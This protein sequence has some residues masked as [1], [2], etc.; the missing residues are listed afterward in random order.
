MSRM[1]ACLQNV[2]NIQSPGPVENLRGLLD[3]SKYMNFE[4]STM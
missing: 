3:I 4:L 1:H 2:Q